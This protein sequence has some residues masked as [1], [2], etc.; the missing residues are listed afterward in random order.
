MTLTDIIV[1]IA[2]LLAVGGAT[3]YIIHAKKNGKNAAGKNICKVFAEQ[4]F[5]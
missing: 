2:I 3:A 5:I 1:L 4:Q